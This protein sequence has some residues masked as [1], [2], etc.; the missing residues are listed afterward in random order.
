MY[1]IYI[2]EKKKQ[3]E[4]EVEKEKKKILDYKKKFRSKKEH[5]IN[6]LY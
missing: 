2:A 4:K 3:R 1:N 5:I 6:I